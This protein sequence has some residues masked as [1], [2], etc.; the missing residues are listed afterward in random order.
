MSNMSRG[1]KVEQLNKTKAA[2]KKGKAK[3]KEKA[4]KKTVRAAVGRFLEKTTVTKAG[5]RTARKI[6]GNPEPKKSG[7]GFGGTMSIASSGGTVERE[8]GTGYDKH[9]KVA[10]LKRKKK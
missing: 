6:G 7:A 4:R 5:K 9:T 3:S 2:A 10:A 8:H 1:R